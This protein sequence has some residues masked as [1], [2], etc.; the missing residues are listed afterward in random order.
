MSTRNTLTI[1]VSTVSGLIVFASLAF[2][3]FLPWRRPARAF[4]S[5]QQRLPRLP[6]G[7]V[8]STL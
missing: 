8:P 3:R 5:G 6:L 4:L 1:L 7:L 2:S